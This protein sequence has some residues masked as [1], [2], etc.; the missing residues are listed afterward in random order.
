MYRNKSA[1]ITL[2]DHP[3]C[4]GGVELD[5]ENPWV[6]L[7]Q[8][9]PWDVLD[10]KYSA[11]FE[12]PD[13]GNPA[14]PARM[15]L[16]SH[17]IKERYGFSDEDTVAEIQ[18]N[19]YLQYF[20]GM[21]VFQHEPPFDASTMTLFRKRLST[22]MLS[23]VN[24]YIIGRKKR[25]DDEGSGTGKSQTKVGKT[26]SSDNEGTLILDAT[27][28]PANIRFPTDV[29][30]LND[31]REKSEGIIDDHHTP[32]TPKPRTY[33]KKARKQYLQFVRNRKPR[34]ADIRKAIKRQLGYVARDIG[35]IKRLIDAGCTLTPKQEALFS[36]IQTVYEQQQQ[37]YRNKSHQTENRIV[38]LHQPW[39]RPIVRGKTVNP[40]EFGAKVAISL[41]GGYA[42]VERLDWNAYN[43][44]KTLQDSVERYK[45]QTGH[46]PK[47]ILADKIY[48]T[49]ENRAYCAEHG[50]RMNGPKLGRPPQDRELYRE[51]CR[52]ERLESGER[53]AVE[54]AFGT[55]K[56]RYSLGKIMTRLKDTS[57]TAIYLVFLV[58]NLQKRLRSLLCRI[59]EMLWI[60]FHDIS[61]FTKRAFGQ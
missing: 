38:S 51:Q 27:C 5:I 59:F 1:Q 57:E 7:A 11:S 50:I 8:M 2:L 26:E 55:G 29:S 16:G 46:Y 19:P 36:T 10:K 35:I 34:K 28:A 40:T 4:F 49:R 33:R 39:I 58:M 60:D 20:I 37:M 25:D 56:R 21:R 45:A 47:R 30:L 43:E 6:K 32:G 42:T 18:M 15:A 31:C 54:G 3:I 14:K 9:I 13:K 44:S 12:N 17:I 41:H 53:N 52:Q 23:E 61:I 48:R 22:E 24:D